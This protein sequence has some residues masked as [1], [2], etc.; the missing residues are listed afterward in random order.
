[1]SALLDR[2]PAAV[3][4]SQGFV[5]GSKRISLMSAE[6]DRNRAEL[7]F[8]TTRLSELRAELQ[9][10]E[11][12]LGM[13]IDEETAPKIIAEVVSVLRDAGKAELAVR[14]ETAVTEAM[15]AIADHQRLIEDKADDVA[16]SAARERQ[17]DAVENLQRVDAEVDAFLEGRR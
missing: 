12:E 11:A 1:M 13:P 15:S 5:R 4:A 16:I 14:Y 2:R 7:E 3:R 17:D 9:A 8:L 6:D 10:N